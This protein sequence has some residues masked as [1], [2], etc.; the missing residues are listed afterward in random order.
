MTSGASYLSFLSPTLLIC[1]M[2]R[3]SFPWLL[4]RFRETCSSG[5]KF[6]VLTWSTKIS[7]GENFVWKC[8]VKPLGVE[9]RR[10]KAKPLKCVLRCCSWANWKNSL[11]LKGGEEKGN[12]KEWRREK[13]RMVRGGGTRWGD[14]RT[15]QAAGWGHVRGWVSNDHWP[16]SCCK[17][18]HSSVT[19]LT[20]SQSILL[21]SAFA[22]VLFVVWGIQMPALRW[23]SCLC[24]CV[25]SPHAWGRQDSQ[26]LPELSTMNPLTQSVSEWCAL[27]EGFAEEVPLPNTQ[28]GPNQQN[29]EIPLD[30]SDLYILTWWPSNWDGCL[31]WSFLLQWRTRSCWL[32]L[33]NKVNFF[34]VLCPEI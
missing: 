16:L 12:F 22:T 24:L 1:R 19:Q 9:I 4:C 11:L 31:F 32:L 10:Q 34:L 5:A 26:H 8:F 17:T 2:R 28:Q 25:C 7:H 20:L 33:K 21:G 13:V 30:T 27:T 14:P 6:A 23:F 29:L 15:S 3:S 18:S